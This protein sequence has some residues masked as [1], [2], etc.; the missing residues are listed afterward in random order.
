MELLKILSLLPLK[1]PTFS[2]HLLHPS[3]HHFLPG[4]ALTSFLSPIPSPSIHPSISISIWKTY[5]KNRT[6]NNEGMLVTRPACKT[7]T[8]PPV[9]RV[10]WC[11]D[12]SGNDPSVPQV[13]SRVIPMAPPSRQGPASCAEPAEGGP[14]ERQEGGRGEADYRGEQGVD[15]RLG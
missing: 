13:A 12:C 6:N 1:S 14:D 11:W 10:E 8:L 5:L 7:G 9:F 3:H 15:G 2:I 4:P